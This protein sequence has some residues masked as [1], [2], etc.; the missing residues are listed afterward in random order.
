[1]ESTSYFA[2]SRGLVIGNDGN[3]ATVHGNQILNYF[4]REPERKTALTIYDQVMLG[5]IYRTEDLGV[6]TY[7]RRWDIR[8][9]RWWE[10]GSQY[11]RADRT[12]CAAQVIGREGRIFTVITYTGPEAQQAFEKDFQMFSTSIT[13]G[14]FQVYGMN[15]NVPTVLFYDGKWMYALMQT[16]LI[17]RPER[18]PLAKFLDGLGFLGKLY[19]QSLKKKFGCHK[20]EVWL[21]PKKGILCQGPAGPKCDTIS[22]RC[23]PSENLPCSAELLQDGHCLS[24]LASLDAKSVDREV[25]YVIA[26]EFSRGD[27]KA[28]V[29]QPTI[30]SAL[31]NATVA[32]GGGLWTN[33]ADCLGERKA[34]ENGATRFMLEDKGDWIWMRIGWLEECRVWM[35]QA[36]SI[37]HARGISLNDDLSQFELIVPHL[38]LDGRLS[39]SETTRQRRREKSIY[40]FVGPLSPSTPTEVCATSLLHYWSFDPT[41]Q[42]PLPAEMC[43]D[44]GLP[45]QLSF[46][47]FLR[48]QWFWKNEAYKWMHQYQVS[49]G[50]DPKTTDFARHLGYPIYHVQSD[51]DRFKDI[52]NIPSL[53][54]PGAATAASP[55]QSS[56]AVSKS[57]GPGDLSEES[58]YRPNTQF[59]PSQHAVSAPFNNPLPHA[60]TSL[61]TA[62]STPF[63]SHTASAGSTHLNDLIHSGAVT[64]ASPVQSSLAAVTS[65]PQMTQDRPA[66]EDLKRRETTRQGT[67]S[68]GNMHSRSPPKATPP[69]PNLRK[70][71]RTPGNAASRLP[72]KSTPSVSISPPNWPQIQPRE[73][74]R[75][76][77]SVTRDAAKPGM[78]SGKAISGSS[79]TRT[80]LPSEPTHIAS[81]S[82][83]LQTPR[84]TTITPASTQR[85]N[86]SSSAAR[87]GRP[88]PAPS[89][90][91]H[92][93]IKGN[94]TSPGMH[95]NAKT[96]SKAVQQCR[97]PTTPARPTARP[98]KNHERSS[99]SSQRVWR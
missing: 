55:A 9:R 22:F 44:L 56:S 14:P 93:G 92:S 88:G 77:G 35:S 18:Q 39:K 34:M 83:K 79:R 37:F 10:E 28:E 50:F 31:M 7:P 97:E 78:T 96:P 16:S 65:L 53:I 84:S 64:V 62:P 8:G 51:S 19:L 46:Y 23:I 72:T 47:V 87:I 81:S 90:G 4:N 75:V 25:V 71:P 82:A 89:T 98:T 67:A 36:L 2:N 20:N 11:L 54:H 24:F 42:H 26:Q 12:V 6:S 99:S 52:D 17:S 5:D 3:F 95:N 49:R 76:R 58:S 30:C 66:K 68:Q 60:D 91:T 86:P 29:H 57:L 13:T 80:P 32:V 69:S 59:P 73:S 40:L 1:M 74:T 21:D 27:S 38:E 15:T 33:S 61:A 43:E 94:A 45:I 85:A 41:G 70:F 63:D 48:Y